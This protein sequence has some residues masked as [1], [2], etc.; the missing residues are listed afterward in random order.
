MIPSVLAA[1]LQMTERLDWLHRDVVH[2]RCWRCYGILTQ[3]AVNLHSFSTLF[4]SLVAPK[5]SIHFHHHH[6]GRMQSL[7][8]TGVARQ[9]S[10]GEANWWVAMAHGMCDGLSS[11]NA[12][13]QQSGK[14]MCMR[15]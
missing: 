12:V 10:V 2:A 15:A 5:G 3:M 13:T 7:V 1:L 4:I 8:P 14:A 9:L 6:E 11:V